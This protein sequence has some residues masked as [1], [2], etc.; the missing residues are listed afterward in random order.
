[1]NPTCK[2]CK[3][4]ISDTFYFCPNCGK[5]LKEPPFRFSWGKTIVIVLESIFLPPLGLIPGIRYLLKDNTKAQILGL[6]AIVI[7]FI[8]TGIVIIYSIN[9]INSV[10][11]NYDKILETQFP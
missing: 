3:A 7:T 4:P 5:K 1:M 9:F 8:S 11:N 10:Q 6:A 2:Y